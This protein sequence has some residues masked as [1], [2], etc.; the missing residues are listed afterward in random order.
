MRTKLVIIIILLSFITSIRLF[1][2]NSN[3]EEFFFFHHSGRYLEAFQ[4][5][6]QSNLI[7]NI[8]TLSIEYASF[9][10][11]LGECEAELE[12]YDNAYNHLNKA[13]ELC[14][15]P[16]YKGTNIHINTLF[17]MAK[18]YSYMEEDSLCTEFAEQAWSLSNKAIQKQS[19]E[20]CANYFKYYNL[21]DEDNINSS[22]K[23][24]VKTNGYDLLKA[25]M[26][27]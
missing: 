14:S 9:L 25:N 24:Y 7:G 16:Q 15:T 8:D 22:I 18:L 23:E 27:V 21:T 6:E 3:L 17:Q 19:N 1:A 5:V 13:I 20:Y 2:T 26:E 12:Y 10:G 11:C 4:L